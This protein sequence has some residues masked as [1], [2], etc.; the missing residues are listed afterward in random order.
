MAENNKNAADKYETQT[1]AAKLY[2]S[3]GTAYAQALKLYNELNFSE[4]KKRFAES[5]KAF[6]NA[7]NTAFDNKLQFLQDK[8]KEHLLKVCKGAKVKTK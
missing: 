8:A 7:E 3:A 2:S 6:K 4:A 1:Y 5:V